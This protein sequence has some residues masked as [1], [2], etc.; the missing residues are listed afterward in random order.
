MITITKYLFE[1]YELVKFNLNNINTFTFKICNINENSYL[2]WP[3]FA[4]RPP[5]DDETQ[6]PP[7]KEGVTNQFLPNAQKLHNTTSC[8]LHRVWPL[9]VQITLMLP[10]HRRTKL[11]NKTGANVPFYQQSTM[12]LVWAWLLGTKLYIIMWSLFRVFF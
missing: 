1:K 8:L 4:L 2:A 11:F 3:P 6:S 10:D 12:F 5:L 9:F 7:L